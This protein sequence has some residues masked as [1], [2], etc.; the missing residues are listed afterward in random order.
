MRARL[1]ER[2]NTAQAVFRRRGLRGVF[3]AARARLT[4]PWLTRAYWLDEESVLLGR[5]VELRGDRVRVDG[6]TFNVRHPSITTRQKCWFLFDRYEAGEREAV[7][8]FLDPSL[9]VLE[10]GGSIG[11][12]AVLTNRRLNQPHQHVVVEANPDLLERLEEHRDRHGC[13]FRILHRAVAYG[14]P[15]VVFSRGGFLASRVQGGG[16]NPVV[17]RT[18]SVQ[19]ILDG[20]AFAR[21]TLICDIEGEE[22]MVVEHEL[23]VLRERIAMFILEVHPDLVGGDA[24]RRMLQTLAGAGFAELMRR[25]NTVALRNTLLA[26][27]SS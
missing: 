6:A 7:R 4:P 8:R 23:D 14:A 20:V 24:T 25:G 19:N 10:L 21:A 17:V 13:A 26:G 1:G 2:M 27:S 15:D 22:M 3:H 18:T 11:I 9:P 5:L 12:V 16:G